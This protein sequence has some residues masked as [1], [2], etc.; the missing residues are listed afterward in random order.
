MTGG[1]RKLGSARAERAVRPLETLSPTDIADHLVDVGAVV[2]GVPLPA[3]VLN[4]DIG[5]FSTSIAPRNGLEG[6]V[7]SPSHPFAGAVG[8]AVRRVSDSLSASSANESESVAGRRPAD[9][10]YSEPNICA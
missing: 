10:R 8:V 1:Q 2:A 6:T 9:I 7:N 4:D 5:V 3:A